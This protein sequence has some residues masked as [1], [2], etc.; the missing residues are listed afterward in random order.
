[1]LAPF[2]TDIHQNEQRA[3]TER[4]GDPSRVALHLSF[5]RDTTTRMTC[6]N[7]KTAP[8][9]TSRGSD[10]GPNIS[11]RRAMNAPPRPAVRSTS[12]G[13][14]SNAPTSAQTAKTM[15]GSFTKPAIT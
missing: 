14:H 12:A 2:R 10:P 6:R 9:V 4:K 13:V 5:R 15:P 11:E 3:G 8:A 1:M 7:N